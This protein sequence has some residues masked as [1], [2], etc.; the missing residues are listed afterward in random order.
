[1]VVSDGGEKNEEQAEVRAQMANYIKPYWD[2]TSQMQA[3]TNSELEKLETS[4]LET[5]GEALEY[6]FIPFA[7]NTH[8]RNVLEGMLEVTKSGPSSF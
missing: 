7:Y 3:L 6:W 2:F 5:I 1:M 8:S 4:T